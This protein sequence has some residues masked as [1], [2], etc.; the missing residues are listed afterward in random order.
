MAQNKY[1]LL[2]VPGRGDKKIRPQPWYKERL[3]TKYIKSKKPND[4]SHN[5]VGRNW[6]FIK[7]NV[8]DFRDGKP[9]DVGDGFIVEGDKGISPVISH[10]KRSVSSNLT[11]VQSRLT[12]EQ[13]VFS[14]SLPLQEE[15]RNYIDEM[16]FG[17]AQHPLAL[18]P[19][20]EEGMPP[21]LFEE[22]VNILDPEM[23][24]EAE[25]DEESTAT[26]ATR[27]VIIEG[28]A[29]GDLMTSSEDKHTVSFDLIEL[30][31]D[32]N[33]PKNPYKW[34][35]QRN[36]TQK[37][38]KKGSKKRPTSPSQDEHIKKVT[39]EFCDW[40]AGLGGESN[41][42]EESTIMSL[43]AS[44]YETKPALSVPIHVVE[45]TNVPMELRLSAGLSP[46][47]SGRKSALSSAATTSST[48]AKKYG[49][50][51]QKYMPSWV[52]VKYGAW[53]LDPK[54]WTPR[55]DGDPLED[56]EEVKRR[57]QSESKK[58]SDEMD[59]QLSPLHGAKA[60]RQF[61][62]RGN[63]RKPDFM[64]KVTDLQDEAEGL[65]SPPADERNHRL[66]TR[67]ELSR[68]SARVN[69]G[70]TVRSIYSTNR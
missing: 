64:V 8:D 28:S 46:I 42:V 36:M 16:E 57:E 25:T 15:R 18:Y 26:S 67:R 47:G 56:P 61:L 14:K 58:K 45:L 4:P 20:L 13:R 33:K 41:N 65:N 2:L 11:N 70:L 32:K 52:K 10:S 23:N 37:D 24:P 6:V 60:F 29:A 54:S 48:E 30:Q 17:L 39:K 40:V 3:R 66:G 55:A 22:V 62:E 27:D 12:K 5:L 1:D 43:F 34:I 59:A 69:S 38:D 35:L 44:G 68:N 63:R 7:S 51:N 19:H 21:E 49:A 31:Q 53:Y 9:L 50:E